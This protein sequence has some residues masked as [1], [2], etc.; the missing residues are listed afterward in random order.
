LIVGEVPGCMFIRCR[1]LLQALGI[2]HAQEPSVVLTETVFSDGD[3]SV[4]LK[5]F[6]REERK[7]P[8]LV[9][10]H[11]KSPN[12][13]QTL[14]ALGADDVLTKPIDELIF[15]SCLKSILHQKY[16]SPLS[17]LGKKEGI[18]D[19]NFRRPVKMTYLSEDSVSFLCE[20]PMARGHS[21]EL[22]V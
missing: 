5:T 16:V 14:F 21:T 17:F 3:T 1:T 7:Y 2:L 19:F 22:S 12:L 10:T 11:D 20:F 15:N 6:P 13:N 18:A 9:I 8:I 4:L